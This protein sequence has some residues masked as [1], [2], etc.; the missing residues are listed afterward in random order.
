MGR[1]DRSGGV[2]RF[3]SD[4]TGLERDAQGTSSARCISRVTP[5]PDAVGRLYWLDRPSVD[6]R[7]VTGGPLPG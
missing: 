6:V 5:L 3:G 7:R 2:N 1:V 4:R